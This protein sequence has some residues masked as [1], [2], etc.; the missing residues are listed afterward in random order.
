[1][2]F[3]FLG[4][5]VVD[6]DAAGSW[7]LFICP[8]ISLEPLLASLDPSCTS[9]SFHILGIQTKLPN[10][11]HG[12]FPVVV[13]FTSMQSQEQSAF[14]LLIFGARDEI[15]IIFIVFS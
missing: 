7:P 12:S 5:T 15:T 2:Q 1:M 14:D 13:T 9:G 10:D 11:N 4:T 8:W 6:V 3:D